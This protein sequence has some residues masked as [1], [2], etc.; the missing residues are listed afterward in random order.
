[1]VHGLS[2]LHS[3]RKDD[4]L[5]LPLWGFSRT[6]AW[7][8]VKYVMDSAGIEDGPYKSPKALRHGF[9]INAI[10]CGVPVTKLQRWMGHAKLETTAIYVDAVGAEE[11][12]IAARMWTQPSN[13]L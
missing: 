6:T 1:M 5:A 4:Q 11:R 12:D 7:R 10:L 8:T 2:E 9:G 3:A 13:E